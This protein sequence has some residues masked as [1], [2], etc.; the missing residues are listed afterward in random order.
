MSNSK[1]SLGKSF[2]ALLVLNRRINYN[3]SLY[4]WTNGSAPLKQQPPTVHNEPTPLVAPIG[5]YAE[6]NF[7][8]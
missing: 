6:C 2:L 7:G 4:D 1:R 5:M 8:F 3:P